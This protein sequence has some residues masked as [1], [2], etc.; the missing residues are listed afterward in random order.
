[1]NASA[2]PSGSC[3]APRRPTPG[4]CSGPKRIVPPI[5]L[6][7]VD[8]GVDILDRDVGEPVRRHT[9]GQVAGHSAAVDAVP[10]ENVV[11]VAGAHGHRAVGKAERLLVERDRLRRITRVQLVPAPAPEATRPVRL[12]TAD[13]SEE[14][15]LAPLRVGNPSRAANGRDIERGLDHAAARRGD[16]PRR[17]V[18]VLDRD[19]RDPVRR[20]AAAPG[21]RVA[22]DH[23]VGYVTSAD[24]LVCGVTHRERPKLPPEHLTV[25]RLCLPCIAGRELEPHELPRKPRAIVHIDSRF[26]PQ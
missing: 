12:I 19:V 3:S 24:H 23:R 26:R 18:D 7:R 11:S 25:E 22:A 16:R 9:G 20:L 15:Q 17:R 2:A 10:R 1:M 4:T 8:C 5:V 13:V 21:R 6:A 14:M